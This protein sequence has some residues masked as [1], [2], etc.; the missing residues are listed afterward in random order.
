MND[1][2]LE[3]NT[4]SPATQIIDLFGGV[5]PLAKKLDMAAS[6]V[7]GWKLRN[8]IPAQYHDKLR[9]LLPDDSQNSLN[10]LLQQAASEQDNTQPTEETAR[11]VPPSSAAPSSATAPS[12]FKPA[13]KA[14]ARD[15]N[16]AYFA[17]P[18]AQVR[19]WVMTSLAM[20][21]MITLLILVLIF[22][23]FG[24][25][26]IDYVRNTPA[27]TNSVQSAPAVSSHTDQVSTAATEDVIRHSRDVIDSTLNDVRKI[28]SGMPTTQTELVTQIYEIETMI[29]GLRDRV[30]QL[31]TQ[32]KEKG[33]DTQSIQTQMA[34]ISRRD[35]AAAA[36]L[37]GV[38]QLSSMLDRQ[39]RFQDDLGFLKMLVAHDPEMIKSIDKLAPFA[40]KGLMTKTQ[41]NDTL[42]LLKEETLAAGKHNPNASWLERVKIAASNVIQIRKNEVEHDKVVTTLNQN[43]QSFTI[44]KNPHDQILAAQEFLK[45]DDFQTAAQILK[46]YHGPQ[47]DLIL[48]IAHNMQGRDSAAHVMS[49]LMRKSQNLLDEGQLKTLLSADQ[50]LTSTLY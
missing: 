39:T 41:M 27:Q 21:G 24:Q 34:Q 20:I 19:Y 47:A 37:L 22:L 38:A 30:D 42:N 6:T 40:E 31:D 25:D 33:L 43:R 10:A 35:V 12:R 17:M 29:S 44:P 15:P 4:V 23:F 28:K 14:P 32:I 50:P 46:D 26:I 45:T 16:A 2:A 1:T 11:A 3:Q 36:L 7:Q 9:V 13:E 5:R 48:E 49:I 18:Q 8:H